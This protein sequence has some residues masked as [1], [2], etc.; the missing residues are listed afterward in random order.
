ME[1]ITMLNG[2]DLKTLAGM[3]S[4]N[5]LCY[6][7]AEYMEQQGKAHLDFRVTEPNGIK[8]YEGEIQVIYRNMMEL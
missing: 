4:E 3:L 5:D 1:V 6:L 8:T 7:I 2:K